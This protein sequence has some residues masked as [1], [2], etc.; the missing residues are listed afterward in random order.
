MAAHLQAMFL[1]LKSPPPVRGI[2]EK[3][4]G[5]VLCEKCGVPSSFIQHKTANGIKE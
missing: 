5:A 2:Q 1:W 3:A 4:L